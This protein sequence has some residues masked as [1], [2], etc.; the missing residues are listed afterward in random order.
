MLLLLL[1]RRDFLI[2]RFI[3]FVYIKITT[4]DTLRQMF[5]VVI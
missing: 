3:N 2:S 5:I 4:I 1:G